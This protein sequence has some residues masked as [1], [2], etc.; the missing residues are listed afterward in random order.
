M[1][2]ISCLKSITEHFKSCLD[3]NSKQKQSITP[4]FR[5]RYNF[6]KVKWNTVKQ[7]QVWGS[8]TNALVKFIW[9][10]FSLTLALLCP[11]KFK[12][13]VFGFPL[14]SLPTRFSLSSRVYDRLALKQGENG[15]EVADLTNIHTQWC[16]LEW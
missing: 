5:M 9:F 8:C 13:D 6:T 16:A 7:S 14:S 4:F 15:N 11:I 3:L 2:G 12:P 1:N 10:P